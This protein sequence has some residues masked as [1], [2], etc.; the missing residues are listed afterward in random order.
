MLCYL[1]CYDLDDDRLRDRT[2]KRLL[3]HG[4]RVQESVFELWFRTPAQFRQL[5]IDLRKLLTANNNLR[6]YRLSDTALGDS[7]AL[8]ANPPRTPPAVQIW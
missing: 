8:N 6:W 1:F 4:Q 3:K 5:Q 7:G 2:A